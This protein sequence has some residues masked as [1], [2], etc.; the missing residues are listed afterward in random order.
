M[1]N[2]VKATNFNKKGLS[3]DHIRENNIRR[4]RNI[5]KLERTDGAGPETYLA[6]PS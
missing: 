2:N 5:E 4:L 6:Q 1:S 3:I